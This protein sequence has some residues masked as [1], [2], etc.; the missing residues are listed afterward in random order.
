M[1]LLA[2]TATTLLL[3]ACTQQIPGD[4]RV[5]ELGR[6]V[7]VTF[8]LFHSES[9]ANGC[10]GTGGYD[11]IGQGTQARLT[12]EANSLLG[13]ASLGRGV[14]GS[15]VCTYRA[16]FEDIDPTLPFYSVEVS[17]RGQISHSRAELRAENWT[18]EISLGA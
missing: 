3:C 9:A 1:R 17:D 18:F 7:Q 14:A 12:D 16:T 2:A 15:G 13:V 5:G 6:P 8:A 11:D 10:E 4:G